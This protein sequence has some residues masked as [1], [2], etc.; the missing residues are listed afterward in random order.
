MKKFSSLSIAARV[1][2]I[3]A[4]VLTVCLIIGMGTYV[5]IGSR[6]LSRVYEKD[7]MIPS[8]EGQYE[9][10]VREFSC[11]GG[12]GAELYIR[13][14]GQDKWYNSWMKKQIGTVGTDDYYQTFSN[15]T[16]EVE[17]ERN[18]LTVYYCQGV[19]AERAND[20]STW[21]GVLNYDLT[22]GP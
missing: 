19:P 10:V 22:Q 9:L 11:L 2:I 17:W 13:K 12:A 7:L 16:Y 20:R 21:R 8:P 4:I 1:L 15:G 5:Y 3:I 14:P 6:M 18:H